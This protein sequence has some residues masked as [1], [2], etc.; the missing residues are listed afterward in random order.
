V[1]EVIAEI[2]GF[3]I[4]PVAAEVVLVESLLASSSEELFAK[5]VGHYIEDTATD[6]VANEMV[7]V[8]VTKAMA[9]FVDHCVTAAA[10]DIA[11]EE[12]SLASSAEE[13]LASFVGH[14]IEATAA[15]VVAVANS[16]S[17]SAANI[18]AEV[19]DQFVAAA[20]TEVVAKKSSASSAAAIRVA[21]KEESRATIANV[22]DGDSPTQRTSLA[23]IN[24]RVGHRL[25]GVI[26]TA[27]ATMQRMGDFNE[28]T[29]RLASVSRPP[30]SS[31]SLL[32]LL[33]Y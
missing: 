18:I 15:D 2:V 27:A 17:I 16:L 29:V 14:Y 32:S 20:V 26:E 6:I 19:V 4:P 24:T 11:E 28:E 22:A 25:G 31:V 3:L 12:M 10:A 23:T 21:A 13:L 9:E 1:A 30:R 8:S 7:H 33:L 5:F